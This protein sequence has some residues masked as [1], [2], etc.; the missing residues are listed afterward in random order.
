MGI[1]DRLLRGKAKK[2]ADSPKENVVKTEETETKEV[3]SG[4]FRSPVWFCGPMGDIIV[5]DL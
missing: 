4:P 3:S 1:F 2:R 5:Q